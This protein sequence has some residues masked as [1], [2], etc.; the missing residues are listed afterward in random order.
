VSPVFVSVSLRLAL[1]EFWLW[2]LR[3]RGNGISIQ[4]VFRLGFDLFRF[5]FNA[6]S[7]V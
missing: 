6:T 7:I 3:L 1:S 5:G 4:L 2:Q